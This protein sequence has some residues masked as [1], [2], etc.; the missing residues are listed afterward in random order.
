MINKYED[1]RLPVFKSG[2]TAFDQDL[3]ET[4][5]TVIA[6]YHELMDDMKFADAL[7]EIW[8]LISR[9]NKY[10]DETEP[11]K[12]AKDPAAGEQLAAVM[13][14]LAASL[15][16]IAT[17]I[18]PVMTHAPQEIFTQL[19]LDYTTMALPDLQISDLPA[20]K[21]V[22]A[23]GTPI[24]PRLEAQDEIDFIQAQMTKSDKTKGRAAMAAKAQKQ[25]AAA[26]AEQ[27]TLKAGKAEIRFDKFDKIE[28]RVA[29]IKAV[30]HIKNA[31]KL[32]RFQLDAGDQ[33][34]RQILSGVA[35]VYPDP[36]VLVG[37]KVLIVA[38]LEPRKMRGEISQGMLLSNKHHLVIVSS[39]LENGSTVE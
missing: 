30:D 23:K 24:F 12:L 27:T 19:G 28:L 22:V 3:E 10:I 15:R 5:A 36:A 31:D 20:G 2:V 39:D 1:G 13:A 11:W 33:G 8:K 34:L 25:E 17:L 26:D 21:Q 32:L 37:K 35:A 18:S 38:N 16:V 4:S 29:E 7:T 6:N 9:S 14:H